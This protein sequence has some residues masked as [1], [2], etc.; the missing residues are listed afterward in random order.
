[1]GSA[2]EPPP[3]LEMMAVVETLGIER[4]EVLPAWALPAARFGPGWEPDA[5]Q[6]AGAGRPT[7][8]GSRVPL[9]WPAEPVWAGQ[10]QLPK[11]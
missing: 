7:R 4:A 11:L 6:T 9:W 10:A 8:A 5:A 2:A 1:M 3:A